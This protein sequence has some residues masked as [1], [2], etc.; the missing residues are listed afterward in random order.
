MRKTAM[1]ALATLVLVLGGGCKKDVVPEAVD[2]VGAEDKTGIGNPDN[3]SAVVKAAREALACEWEKTTFSS[4]CEAFQSWRKND[5]IKKGA[6]DITLVNFLEDKDTKI[7]WLGAEA[8]ARAGETYKKD[9]VLAAKILDATDRATEA[10]LVDKL[11]DAAA[12]I[13]LQ[14]T[15]LGPRV[16]AML[17]THSNLAVRQGMVGSRNLSLNRDFAGLFD[18]Y[19]KLARTD[20]DPKV[21]SNA[22]AAFWVGTPKGKKDEVCKLWLELANDADESVASDAAYN[23]AHFS[24]DGGCSGQW[25]ELLTLI[26][27]K[28][29]AGAVSFKAAGALEYVHNQKTAS[30]ALKTRA[31]AI[32][33]TTVANTDNNDSARLIAIRF[34]IK[35][36]PAGK[37]FAKTY[38]N[39]KSTNIKKVAADAQK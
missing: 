1:F 14:S 36:D 15:S 38:E 35:S 34:V 39:D 10:Y 37:A 7:Q 3:D 9:A 33:K 27:Q 28:A 32:A 6:A 8:I 26:E 20:K 31:L 5:G 29:K 22:A 4:K 13:N 25:E 16:M 17:E 19:V 18:L 2:S 23:C 24:S 11:T 21:R 30:P 12:Q